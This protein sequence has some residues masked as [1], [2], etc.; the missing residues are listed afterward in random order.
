MLVWFTTQYGTSIAIDNRHVTSVYE[1]DVNDNKI[2]NINTLN[3]N[4]QV[5]DSVLEV[6]SRLNNAE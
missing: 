4:I 1:S 2:T 6:V 3:G 5:V